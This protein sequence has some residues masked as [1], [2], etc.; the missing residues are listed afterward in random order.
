LTKSHD[1]VDIVYLWVDGNDSVWRAKRRSAAS[2]LSAS[3]RDG[4]AQHGNVEGRY[5]DNDELRY[6]LRALEKFFPA[7]GH[8]YVVTDAQTP[9]WLRSSDRLT[10]VDHQD[11]IPAEHLPT[12]DSSHIE[13]YIHRIPNLSER[14]FY[15]NDDVMFGT[16]V[17]LDDWFFD[18]GFY[19]AWSDEPPVSDEP[20]QQ[21][22]GALENACRLSNAW[23][24]ARAQDANAHNAHNTQVRAVAQGYEHVFR[25]FAHSPRPMRKSFL[26]ELEN[27]A[28][29]MFSR[30]RSTVFRTWDKPTIVSDF[31]LRWALAIGLAKVRD[32]AHLYV[33][34]GAAEQSSVLESLVSLAGK[35]E[36]F[37]INDTTD[38]AYPH[39]PRLIEV[40]EALQRMFP[41]PSSFELA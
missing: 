18:G 24:K 21:D 17:N 32:Y 34:S 14:Y 31:V 28:P 27:L 3:H 41:E 22:A 37:C 5:R 23:F 35:V 12:F 16:Q 7:H 25:T 1:A 33:S 19:V 26:V 11:L 10:V 39:D 4:M 9:A 29:D 8:I 38:D 36:F 20:L 40:R 15:L 2:R 30:V 13:S 6:N